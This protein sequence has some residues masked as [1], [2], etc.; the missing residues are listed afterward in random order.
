MPKNSKNGTHSLAQEFSK[1]S[2]RFKWVTDYI[3]SCWN[4]GYAFEDP[5]CFRREI[6]QFLEPVIADQINAI[7]DMAEMERAILH[8]DARIIILEAE[9][10]MER[11]LRRAFETIEEGVKNCLENREEYKLM[12]EIEELCS[13]DITDEN[14][15]EYSRRM[16]EAL[17]KTKEIMEP[18]ERARKLKTALNKAVFNS[19]NGLHDEM[20]TPL[21]RMGLSRE[22]REHK[23]QSFIARHYDP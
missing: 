23:F 16:R 5:Q 19:R 10:A 22:E 21:R 4:D 13:M 17:L 12:R 6:E 9:L 1:K 14:A 15:A 7:R 3:V 20:I 8:R 11:A 2:Q 18:E